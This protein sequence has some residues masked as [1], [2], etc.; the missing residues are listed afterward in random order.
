M[1]LYA[2]RNSKGRQSATPFEFRRLKLESVPKPD[3]MRK[4]RDLACSLPRFV[5]PGKVSGRHLKDYLHDVLMGEYVRWSR[6]RD[7]VNRS[8]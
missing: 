5:T 6:S 3:A 2:P 1:T 8:P 4:P 7:L